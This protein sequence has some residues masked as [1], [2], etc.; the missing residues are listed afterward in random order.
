MQ[1]SLTFLF[2]CSFE[3]EE[4]DCLLDDFVFLSNG[5]LCFF[6]WLVGLSF[7]VLL[8]AEHLAGVHTNMYIFSAW[9]EKL[10]AKS[11]KN[12]FVFLFCLFVF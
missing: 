8:S 11:L 12:P 1:V 5:M 3:T 9:G 2:S 10:D 6:V 4:S 7:V